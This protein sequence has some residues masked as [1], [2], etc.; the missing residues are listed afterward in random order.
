MKSSASTEYLSSEN[1]I[2]RPLGRSPAV[3]LA[4]DGGGT[5]GGGVSPTLGGGAS[6]RWEPAC[7]NFHISP[8]TGRSQEYPGPK[9]PAIPL[10]RLKLSGW[11]VR[12]PGYTP[13][14]RPARDAQVKISP[15]VTG[16]AIRKQDVKILRN[17]KKTYKAITPIR[18]EIDSFSNKS[19]QRLRDV[20]ANCVPDLISSFCLTYHQNVPTDGRI[21]KRHLDLLLKRLRR[22][23]E[24][25]K[26]LWILEFQTNRQAPH[27]H[28]FFT[29]EPSEE[30]RLFL[31]ES[32]NE[33][34]GETESHKKW[35]AHPTN[36]FSWDMGEGRY[37]TKYLDKEAQ[38]CVPEGFSFPGRFWGCS[39]GLVPPPVM[40]TEQ[41]LDEFL[42][43]SL[44]PQTGEIYTTSAKKYIV[45]TLCRLIEARTRQT[46]AK[47]KEKGVKLWKFRK[48]R[49]RRI[50]T[51]CNLKCVA[52]SFWKIYQWLYEQE[53]YNDLVLS[54]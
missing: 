36:F 53:A 12:N 15:G 17:Y 54:T 49:S 26:Y 3:W 30:M 32:W 45:R 2:T 47:L 7:F 23:Y 20:C 8:Q 42:I 1:A 4:N 13:K 52:S 14:S 18:G 6:S 29:C 34:T 37:L 33:I 31:A 19:R 40:V 5:A 28:L 22:R 43:P 27:F 9:T 46:R 39:R 25:L 48:D 11:H 38:K 35:H 16:L 44:N 41:K 10:E 50:A 24:G 51:S 21:A